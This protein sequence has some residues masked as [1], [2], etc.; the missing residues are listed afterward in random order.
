MG[1][2]PQARLKNNALLATASEK[3]DP[4]IN[5][6]EP[7]ATSPFILG[8]LHFPCETG[9]MSHFAKAKLKNNVFPRRTVNFP[10]SVRGPLIN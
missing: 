2:F 4:L 8:I 10:S 5:Y 1:K 9:K 3:K 7:G 6:L